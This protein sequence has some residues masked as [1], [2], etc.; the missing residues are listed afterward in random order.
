M[1]LSDGKWME[2]QFS[3]REVLTANAGKCQVLARACTIPM[4]FNVPHAVLYFYT[5]IECKYGLNGYGAAKDGWH[6]KLHY[7]SK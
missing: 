4:R 5:K 2:L 7:S 6:R 3:G 1:L